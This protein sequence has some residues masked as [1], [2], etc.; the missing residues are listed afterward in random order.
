MALLHCVRAGHGLPVLGRAAR[1]R[2]GLVNADEKLD[3]IA[4]LCDESRSIVRTADVRAVLDAPSAP[5]A[6]PHDAD[7]DA[8]WQAYKEREW[9]GWESLHADLHAAFLAGWVARPVRSAA[10][11]DGI[12]RD[13]LLTLG[14]EYLD[15]YGIDGQPTEHA[16]RVV[17]EFAD[18]VLALV[19]P[20]PPALDLDAQPI[21]GGRL[22]PVWA[23]YCDACDAWL[24]EWNWSRVE[25]EVILREH[26]DEL[27]D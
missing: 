19:Q 9:H 5:A 7:A 3:A 25:A 21:P 18:A 20:A 26:Q 4:A 2:G 23:V 22:K 24:T 11:A 12:D 1:H 27:H 17:S 8:A 14:Y 16:R 15:P 10:R 13:A 6:Q